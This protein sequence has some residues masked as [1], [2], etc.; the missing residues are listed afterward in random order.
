LDEFE[1]DAL[2]GWSKASEGTEKMN[3]LDKQYKS[4]T[5]RL[6]WF[7]GITLIVLLT[8]AFFNL[9][10]DQNQAKKIA[11]KEITLDKQDVVFSKEIQ[12]LKELPEHLL[13]K[14]EMVVSNFKIKF[15]ILHLDIKKILQKFS[16]I[17]FKILIFQ[18]LK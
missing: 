12:K 14:P 11:K 1:K 13:I 3:R 16:L 18:V 17:I 4:K 7:S 5:Y 2:E 6:I 9:N 8:I 15:C 10:Q